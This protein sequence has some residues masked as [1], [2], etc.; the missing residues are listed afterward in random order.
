VP[1]DVWKVFD[2]NLKLGFPPLS[3]SV[4]EHLP[5]AAAGQRTGSTTTP[6]RLTLSVR[7][8]T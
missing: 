2:P 1:V 6:L 8:P 7:C 3:E 4:P 5:S